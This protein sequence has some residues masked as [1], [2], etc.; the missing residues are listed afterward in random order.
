M[1]H[2]YL[3][4]KGGVTLFLCGFA[5]L[6]AFSAKRKMRGHPPTQAPDWPRLSHETLA[7]KALNQ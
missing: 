6:L 7:M 4:M 3:V 5:K 1:K 2:H